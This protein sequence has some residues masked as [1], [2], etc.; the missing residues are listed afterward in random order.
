MGCMSNRYIPI[1]YT[2]IKVL[3]VFFFCLFRT[4]PTAYERSLGR[5][6]IEAV[7]AGLHHSHINAGWE[8][9]VQPTPQPTDNAR[10][11]T[12]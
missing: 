9:C 5:S 12:H 1:S 6:Q 11:L 8:P 7:A 2:N 10:S 3:W 4:A